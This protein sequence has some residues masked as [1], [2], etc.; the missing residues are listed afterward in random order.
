MQPADVQELHSIKQSACI[1]A[2]SLAG[3]KLGLLNLSIPV[4]VPQLPRAFPVYR[5]TCYVLHLQGE[6]YNPVLQ[7]SSVKP[8]TGGA[9]HCSSV[10]HSLRFANERLQ[11]CILPFAGLA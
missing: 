8:S 7:S 3:D 9:F 10:L 6:I 4:R 11:P 1:G 2:D 5:L